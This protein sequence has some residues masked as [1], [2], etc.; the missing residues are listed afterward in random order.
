M[1]GCRSL[2]LWLQWSTIRTGPLRM[3]PYEARGQSPEPERGKSARSTK[4][5]GDGRDFPRGRGQHLSSRCSRRGLWCSTVASSSSC[6]LSMS[7]C[8]RWWNS[9]WKWTRS[10]A[11]SCLRLPSRLSKCPSLLFLFVLFNARLCLS[12]SW[13]NSL[14]VVPTVLSYS[15]LKQRTAEQVVDTPVPH[16]RGGGALGGLQGFS[17]GQ[18]ST[19]VC[20]ADQ[21][22]S[23]AL[24]GRGGVSQG[25]GSTAVC[26]ADNVVSPAPHGRGG[27][28]RGGL[29]GLSQ[30][31]GSSAVCGADNVDIPVPHGRV[32]KRGLHDF[33]PR[34]EFLSVCCSAD[35]RC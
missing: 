18:D 10:F 14:V 4:P 34:T 30:G 7:L 8:F 11:I 27:G 23:P 1:N 32:G 15:L 19:E 5:Y 25:Q 35:R 20:G 2:W 33:P 12:R 26:G 3:T 21:V 9:L 6:R 17:Q 31:Q 13:W 29:Q 24:H 22:V 28:A 16:G